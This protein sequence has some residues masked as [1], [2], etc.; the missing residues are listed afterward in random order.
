[1]EATETASQ[2]ATAEAA[3]LVQPSAQPEDGESGASRESI[4]RAQVS[5][6]LNDWLRSG[7]SSE[8][9]T[10]K[11]S[12]GAAAGESASA[13]AGDVEAGGAASPRG[14]DGR[15]LSRRGVPEALRQA[16]QKLAEV[17]PARLRE[18]HW[19]E[20]QTEQTR[21]QEQA[22]LTELSKTQSANVERYR[23][24]QD[25]P[26]HMLDP[27]DYQWREEWKEKLAAFPDIQQFHEID[28]VT[29]IEQSREQDRAHLREQITRSAQREGIDPARWKASGVDWDSMSLDLANAREAKVRAEVQPHLDRLADLERELQQLRPQALGA[30]RAPVAAG[31]SSSAAPQS[32]NDAFNAWLRNAAG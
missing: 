14:P 27:G 30:Q 28:K 8:I 32:E 31:R 18:Q 10:S 5:A 29:Q 21:Q 26:D 6:G 7:G 16:E 25:T 24:L 19:Q 15:F 12:E 17:D 13:D 20:F 23:R 1:M 9:S 4:T 3:A 22:Q 11:P 2:P